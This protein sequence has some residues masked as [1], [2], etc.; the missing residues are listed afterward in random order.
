MGYCNPMVIGP[1]ASLPD[2]RTSGC[3]GTSGKLTVPRRPPRPRGL[4]P[5][6]FV[7]ITPACPPAWGGG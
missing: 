4:F 1:L 6:R 2:G 7:V 3:I 5:S